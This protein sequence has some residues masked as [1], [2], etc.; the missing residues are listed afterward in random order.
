MGRALA[1]ADGA[2]GPSG[3]GG[4]TA[5]DQARVETVKQ[6]ENRAESAILDACACRRSGSTAACHGRASATDGLIDAAARERD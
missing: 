3:E 6:R 2:R 5:G 1:S 4:A